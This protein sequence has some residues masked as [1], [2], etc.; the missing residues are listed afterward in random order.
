MPKRQDRIFPAD[1]FLTTPTPNNSVLI[2][3]HFNFHEE[4][5]PGYTRYFLDLGY[6]VDIL[7]NGPT[8][9][10][11]LFED[12]DI[13]QTR[14]FSGLKTIQKNAK[15][16][17]EKMRNYK[18]IFLNTYE[19]SLVDQLE[20]MELENVFVIL[21]IQAYIAWGGIPNKSHKISLEK[22]NKIITLGNHLI[23]GKMVNPHYFGNI[24]LNPKNDITRFI[25]AYRSR[26]CSGINQSHRNIKMLMDAVTKMSAIKELQDKFEVVIVTPEY[27]DIQAN[28]KRYFTIT[29]VLDNEDMYV[30]FMKSDF[31]LPLLDPNNKSHH[32]YVKDRVTGSAQLIYGFKKPPVIHKLFGDFYGF[33]NQ[34]AVVYDKNSF[35]EAMIEAIK[36]SPNE[37]REKQLGLVNLSKTIYDSSLANLRSIL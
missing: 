2:L 31:I 24:P 13:E 33:N 17:R 8:D 22:R 10:L 3:E 6:N 9:M 25:T 29:G 26:G 23:V 11:C 15:S 19:K 1:S 18:Y 4:C 37:Y 27:S 5:I 36:M 14:V 7:K 16:L 21:H 28:I 20:I 12:K 30:E 35:T 32:M 34:N